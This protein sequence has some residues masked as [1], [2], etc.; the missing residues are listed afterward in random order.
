M[1]DPPKLVNAPDLGGRAGMDN[2]ASSCIPELSG[3]EAALLLAFSIQMP[4][5]GIAV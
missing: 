5:S 3:L 4:F 2:G 1:L